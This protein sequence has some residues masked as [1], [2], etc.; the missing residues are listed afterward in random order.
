M[1]NVRCK[2]KYN[3]AFPQI[4]RM[5]IL[6][7]QAVVVVTTGSNRVVTSAVCYPLEYPPTEIAAEYFCKPPLL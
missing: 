6:E 5:N 7:I 3:L 2:R 4:S 1:S